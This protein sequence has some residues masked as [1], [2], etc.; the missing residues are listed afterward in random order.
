MNL[1][2]RQVRCPEGVSTRKLDR[3]SVLLNMK[4]EMYY[5]LDETGTRCWDL[6][7]ESPSLDHVTA[8]IACEYNIE[9]ERARTD[10]HEFAE[11]LL[12]EGLIVVEDADHVA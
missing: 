4:N 5:G 10:V 6:M 3:E 7:L 12:E 8:T 11:S 1:M 9:L 2:A